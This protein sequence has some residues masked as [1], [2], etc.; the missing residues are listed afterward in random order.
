[1]RFVLAAAAQEEIH[2]VGSLVPTQHTELLALPRER[3]RQLDKT[4]LPGVWSYRTKK[5][6]LRADRTVLVTFNRPL[7]RAQRRPCA[8]RSTSANPTRTVAGLA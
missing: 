1:V 5:T 7:L 8:A 3:M 4:Q 2:F 6:V